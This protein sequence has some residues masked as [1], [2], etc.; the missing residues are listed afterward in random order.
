[1]VIIKSAVAV[2]AVFGLQTVSDST[3]PLIR[4]VSKMKAAAAVNAPTCQVASDNRVTTTPIVQG[5][6]VAAVV[7]AETVLTVLDIPVTVPL[8]AINGSFVVTGP[9][10]TPIVTY[11]LHLSRLK[12]TLLLLLARFLVPSPLVSSSPSVSSTAVVKDRS[13]LC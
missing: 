8:I 7:N 11:P 2:M 5:V 3:V 1:M 4:I 6:K 9:A 12:T 13:P 10:H